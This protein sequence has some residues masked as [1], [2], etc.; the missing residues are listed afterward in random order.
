MKFNTGVEN[1]NRPLNISYYRNGNTATEVPLKTIFHEFNKLYF[2][3]SI[4]KHKTILG[5]RGVSG[6]E[7][8]FLAREEFC[9]FQQTAK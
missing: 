9:Q 2:R 4:Y 7:E 5:V 8:G 3:V 6:G 1:L